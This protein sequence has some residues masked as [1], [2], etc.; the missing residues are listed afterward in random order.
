MSE[1]KNSVF[2]SAD[3]YTLKNTGVIL[4]GV[5]VASTSPTKDKGA[6]AESFK[7]YNPAH[8]GPYH[9]RQYQYYPEYARTSMK[10]M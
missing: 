3:Y 9:V 7:R 10:Q 6:S 2:S 8:Y 1:K 5:K 4:P